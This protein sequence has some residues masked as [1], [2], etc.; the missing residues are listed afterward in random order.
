M[1]CIQSNFQFSLRLLNTITFVTLKTGE[2]FVR[3][4]CQDVNITWYLTLFIHLY[5]ERTFFL[6]TFNTWD[7]LPHLLHGDVDE[8]LGTFYHF[9]RSSTNSITK[10]FSFSLPHGKIGFIFFLHK[11]HYFLNALLSLIVIWPFLYTLTFFFVLV[12]L[13]ACFETWL[14]F[15]I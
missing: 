13:F 12:W 5:C 9:C 10:E 4:Y 3:C 11:T 6:F 14:T 7:T 8:R 2:F 15:S 1:K